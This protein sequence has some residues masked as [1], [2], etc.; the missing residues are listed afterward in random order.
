[1]KIS[2]IS[3]I[4][5]NFKVEAE[6]QQSQ[7]Q[8]AIVF[9]HQRCAALWN[10]EDVETATVKIVDESLNVIAEKSEMI[11]HPIIE[12]AVIEPAEE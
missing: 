11:Q 7:L 1:M 3:V 8:G 6:Y 4:N 2:V 9:F 10:A 5:G 12:P